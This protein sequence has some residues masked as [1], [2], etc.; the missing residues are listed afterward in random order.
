MRVHAA[1]L[2]NAVAPVGRGGDPRP[3]PPT[4]PTRAHTQR[5]PGLPHVAMG[6]AEPWG[7]AVILRGLR[8]AGESPPSN[9]RRLLG[10]I[11][12]STKWSV[13]DG[14]S[15]MRQEGSPTCVGWGRRFGGA[16]CERGF[17]GGAPAGAGS[18]H[19]H[20]LAETPVLMGRLPLFKFQV[21]ALL[22]N[23]SHNGKEAFLS[24]KAQHQRRGDSRLKR[25][26]LAPAARR[27]GQTEEEGTQGSGGAAGPGAPLWAL[28]P[29]QA[30]AEQPGRELCDR[31]WRAPDSPVPLVPQGVHGGAA[32][33]P[34]DQVVLGAH[35]GQEAPPS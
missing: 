1:S 9:K 15:L 29:A 26:N 32:G 22:Y 10:R 25:S 11:E 18:G 24:G 4:A 20:H 21:F 12:E 13:A 30:A 33:K 23:F 5:V 35:E 8:G 19:L 2:S 34:P 7:P 16:A 27:W 3:R 31:A 6:T 14:Q 17:G 28:G